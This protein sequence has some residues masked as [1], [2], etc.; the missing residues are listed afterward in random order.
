MEVKAI[1]LHCSKMAFPLPQQTSGQIRNSKLFQSITSLYSALTSPNS[2][3]AAARRQRFQRLAEKYP[4]L[5]GIALT[6]A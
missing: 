3:G 5:F 1:L 2:T 4:Q 6:A